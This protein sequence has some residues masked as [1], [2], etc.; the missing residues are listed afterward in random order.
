MIAIVSTAPK[1]IAA[2]T[3]GPI[4]FLKKNKCKKK[5]KRYEEKC[6]ELMYLFLV[7]ARNA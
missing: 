6:K 1:T 5:K 7:V 2:I 4:S 3:P